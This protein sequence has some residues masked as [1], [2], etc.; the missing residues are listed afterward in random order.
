VTIKRALIS[1]SHKEGIIEFAKALHE[2]GI[3]IIST[4]GTAKILN[5]NGITVTLVSEIT[6]FDEILDGRVKTLHP[7]IHGALLAR[8]DVASDIET[9]EAHKIQPIE[10]VVVNLYPFEETIS[11]ETV[12]LNEAVEQIDIGGPTMIRA[13]AKNFEH[14]A[15]IVNPKS[16]SRIIAELDT[17]NG[18]LTENTLF[19]LAVEAFQH[20]AHYDS[21]IAAYLN[22]LTEH[23]AAIPETLTV[24]LRKE[25]PLRYGENPHQKAA[26]F[27]KFS[28]YF[29]KLHGKELSY[30]NILDITAA[31]QV[32]S[33]FERPSVAIIKHNNPCGVA[34]DGSLS[35]AYQKALECDRTS[36]FGGIVACNRPPDMDMAQ[37]MNEIFTE[38]IVAPSYDDDVL[39]FLQKK[40]DRRLIRQMIDLKNIRELDIRSVF[41]GFLV[42]DKD[43]ER[44]TKERLKVVTERKP[45]EHELESLLFAWRVAK[46]IKSNAIVFARDH[47]TLG[48]GAG[49]MSR[50]DS[51]KIAVKKS[52]DAGFDL[53]K[54]VVA[55]DGFFPFADGVIELAKAGAVAIIQPGGSIRD[56]E[57]IEA[58]NKHNISMVFTGIRHFRH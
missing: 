2:R 38:V 27:G 16:Y 35:A 3:R 4:G 1:V 50:V 23:A 34:S 56:D 28:K 18:T 46:H 41:G 10:M 14:R 53:S 49:Q 5:E 51:S 6:G 29:R 43:T 13:A 47:Q 58:A 45:D 8:A 37:A 9:L 12:A 25:L 36:A 44:L 15:V 39:A 57:V 11:K 21:I 33:E 42:Q 17:N 30:N 26:L 48:I 19:H 32:V 54:S 7:S 52:Q 22:S 24:S 20:T 40:K 55:S 31:V